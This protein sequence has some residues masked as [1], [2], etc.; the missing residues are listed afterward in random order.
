MYQTGSTAYKQSA[1]NTVTDKREILLKLYAGAI[2]FINCAKRGIMEKSPRIRGENISKT[3]DI[4]N[5]LEC[6]LDHEKGG[7]ISSRLSS[8]YQYITDRLGFASRH[9][10]IE[11]LEQVKQIISILKDGFEQ[12]LKEQK[13]AAAPSQHVMPGVSSPAP[14]RGVQFAL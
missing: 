7:E 9:N 2:S 12:A 6:A 14:E 11:T 5:E 8:L 10:D 3:L 4:I 1:A 13:S